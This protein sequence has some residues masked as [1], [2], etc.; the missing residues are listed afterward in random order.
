MG[1]TDIQVQ[2]NIRKD[3]ENGH[4]EGEF[5]GDYPRPIIKKIGELSL[6]IGDK[7][8]NSERWG[9]NAVNIFMKNP[10]L[11]FP[12]ENVWVNYPDAV[13]FQRGIQNMKVRDIEFEINVPDINGEIDYNLIQKI[14]WVALEYV[15]GHDQD[16]NIALE[17]RLFKGSNATLAPE[18]GY[19][20]VCS[21]EILRSMPL[22]ADQEDTWKQHCLNI[23]R[24][25]RDLR[26]SN[27]NAGTFRLIQS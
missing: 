12:S 17:M 10:F 3:K 9:E 14:W 18:I 23:F 20:T 19:G 26:D 13:H 7:F 24:L 1:L 21:I 6:Y 22:N 25:W 15:E 11:F 27:G 16:I 4:P 2:N 5:I 8:I